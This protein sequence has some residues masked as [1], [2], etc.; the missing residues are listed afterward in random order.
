MSALFEKARQGIAA[1]AD[2][3]VRAVDEAADSGMSLV[4][5]LE[6]SW[7]RIAEA[8]VQLRDTLRQT[9]DNNGRQVSHFLRDLGSRIREKS[10]A[11][12]GRFLSLRETLQKEGFEAVLDN[13]RAA[14]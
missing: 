2:Q 4:D 13:L 3:V 8:G 9:T 10:H 7:G 5:W 6:N 14:S 12:E 11:L 1:S